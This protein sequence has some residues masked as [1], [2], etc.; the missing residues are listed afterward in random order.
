LKKVCHSA[1]ALKLRTRPSTTTSMKVFVT[2]LLAIAATLA[3]ADVPEANTESFDVN[4]VGPD[5]K[6]ECRFKPSGNCRPTG[7]RVLRKEDDDLAAAPA[8]LL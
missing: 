4:M 6:G 2:L 5:P 1:F 7:G 8:P 3:I